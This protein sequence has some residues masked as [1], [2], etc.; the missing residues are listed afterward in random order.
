[1]KGI[2]VGGLPIRCQTPVYLHR[3][4]CLVIPEIKSEAQIPYF[5]QQSENP[6]CH[7]AAA[8]STQPSFTLPPFV[9]WKT[10][11]SANYEDPDLRFTH[12]VWN[13]LWES[14]GRIYVDMLVRRF[15]MAIYEVLAD[16]ISA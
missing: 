10:L 12:F 9:L 2:G 13:E 8:A 5:A 16:R 15:S 11:Y 6:Q 4:P 3:Y 7:P 1:M 14:V